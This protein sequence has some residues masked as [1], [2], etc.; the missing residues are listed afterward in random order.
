[1]NNPIYSCVYLLEGRDNYARNLA[2]G[3]TEV[4][5]DTY[6]FVN[7]RAVTGT[8]TI[9]G[10]YYLFDEFGRM[11]H[12][13]DK[14]R[15]YGAD[16][17]AANGWEKISDK[18]YY[19]SESGYMV[20][21][22]GPI[23]TVDGLYFV[24]EG[25]AVLKTGWKQ[26]ESGRWFYILDGGKLCTGW[27]TIKN[28][29]YF[30]GNQGVMLTGWQEIDG[31]YY[32]FDENGHMCTDIQNE[33]YIIGSDGKAFS[34]WKKIDGKWHYYTVGKASGQIY[35]MQY[36]GLVCIDWNYYYFIEDHEM[37]TGWISYEH[38]VYEQ[39]RFVTRT[40]WVYLDSN[41][42]AVSGWQQIGGNWYYFEKEDY[43]LLGSVFMVEDTIKCINGKYYVFN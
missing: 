24:E 7:G 22:N 10:Y 31:E 3:F 30:F 8:E 27:K 9:D 13:W 6:F 11:Y 36:T 14:Y 32:L 21:W 20:G 18:W 19:F 5:G 38:N 15:Y 16:G 41:G 1:M 40:S 37:Q 34:G 43:S 17:K 42:K 23:S 12:G 2:N 25:A 4:D 26:D 35:T 39:D 29:T 28:N 33:S